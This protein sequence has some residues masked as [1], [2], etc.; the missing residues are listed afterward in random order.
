MLTTGFKNSKES[1]S[2]GKRFTAKS[3]LKIKPQKE[4]HN[5]TFTCQA[6]NLAEKTAKT[7]QVKF[8]VNKIGLYSY[9]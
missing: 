1:L 6:K 5:K 2:D 4:H 9:F 3:I 8:E 7:A